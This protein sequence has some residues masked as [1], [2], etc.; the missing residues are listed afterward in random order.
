MDTMVWSS[1]YSVGHMLIDEQHKEL[2]RRI[3]A[4]GNALWN[5]EGK[6][7]LAAHLRFLADYVV[8][9]FQME[10]GLMQENGFPDYMGHKSLHDAFVQEVNEVLGRIASEGLDSST[11]I[12]VFEKSCDWIRNHVRNVDQ[13]LGKFLASK[14]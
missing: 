10:E 7:Q 13:R 1:N 3:N 8:S 5:G 9:H 6:D 12:A 14:A 11:A 4:L 2:F